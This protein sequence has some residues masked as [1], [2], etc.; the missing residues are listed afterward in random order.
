MQ[1]KAREDDVMTRYL[2]GEL[3]ETEQGAIEERLFLD[4]DWFDRLRVVEMELIDD[5]VQGRMSGADR[6]EFE[7]AFLTT[8]ERMQKVTNAKA[9][10]RHVE[11]LERRVSIVKPE[12]SAGFWQT[13]TGYLSFQ[14]PAMQYAM[15]AA[16]LLMTV[17]A[18]WLVYDRVR[19]AQQLDSARNQQ[20][21]QTHEEQIIRA[22]RAELQKELDNKQSELQRLSVESQG[23][24]KELEGLKNE[25]AALRQRWENLGPHE[26][27]DQVRA[28]VSAARTKNAL[29]PVNIYLKP[30]TKKV[31][32]QLQVNP[33]VAPFYNISLKSKDGRV[34]NEWPLQKPRR[35]RSGRSLFLALAANLLEEGE[36]LLSASD[37][38]Q[39]GR[40]V[41]YPV[42]VFRK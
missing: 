35:T 10:L 21:V 22:Q 24:D 42:K 1:T 27:V 4:D 7:R 18:S 26:P 13:L 34:I 32:L 29:L 33:P 37:A 41:A 38:S 8:P 40:V 14:S 39:M 31:S 5:Y 23:K 2:L 36:Y 9:L 15:A 17:G 6:T 20:A 25:I 11:K 3:A 28:I 12:S 16:V 30:E 19:L